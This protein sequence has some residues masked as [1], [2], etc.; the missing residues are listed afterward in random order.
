MEGRIQEALQYIGEYP[1]AKIATVARE[2]GVPRGRL[3]YRLEGR[4]ALS[5]R[6]PTHAKLTVPEE[7]A[8]CRYIDRLDRINLAVRTEFV[9]DA[10]NTILKERSG[11][12]ES[13]TVGKK[14]TARFLKRH[15]YSKRL[16]KKMHSDRQA[17]EDLERVNAYFQRLSTI[18][19]EEGIPPEDIWNMDE[20]GFRI[21]V[22]K[23]QVI[24][25][26]RK[27]AHYFGL[28]ENRES[29]TA[30][31]SISAGGR[32]LPAFLILS[33]QMHM[34]KWYGVPG[35]DE[36]AAIR[37]TPSGYSND[38]ISLEWL[39]HFNKWSAQSC[40]GKKRLLILD[41]HGSH[42]T[43]QFIQYCDDHDIIPF[44]MPPNLTH[45]LQPLDVAVFQP[46]K[47]YHAKALDIMVR[48]GLVHIGKLEFLSC[49]G[50]VR[51]QAFK[52][53]TIRSAFK[54]TGI[55]PFNP[56]AVLEILAARQPEGT[57]SPP[58]S[59]LQSSPF[60]TPVTLRQMNKV[61][62]KVTRVIR[63]DENL[64]PDLRYEMSRFI[65]GSLSLATEL[66][67]TKRDLGRTKM[68]EHL[69][70]QR[71]ALKNSP[72]QPG[73]VLKVAQGREMVRQRAEDQL[74]KARRMVEAAELK[75]LNARKR[76]FEEAAKEARKWRASERLDRAEVVDSEGGRRLLKRF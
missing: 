70:Q 43:K 76:V 47:H 72:L 64:D 63:E 20:T 10:A 22:G 57:P 23:D 65:R 29:A 71:K 48:D 16:Q 13:L 50:N 8:L 54:K 67:Q 37:P 36:N 9:T 28:P 59:G 66:I 44:G 51:D 62:D 33:G 21:G 74:A 15:K 19:I 69:A 4:T 18:L 58:F 45:I 12:G 61:A 14:W 38:E 41:G 27:R 5:D 40:L 7:K 2:F 42:H 68:A 26:R 52:E 1:H 46:L 34:A 49:I 32:V 24:V 75:A 17:S 56:Q 11:A 39:E 60:S 73:G 35:L 31:E 53:S 6:P 30:I 3:R 55:H 25:T